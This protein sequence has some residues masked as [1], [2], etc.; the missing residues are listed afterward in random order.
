[1]L[2]RLA[3]VRLRPA[4]ILD[5]GAGTGVLG[6][7]LARRFPRARIVALDV[8]PNMLRVGRSRASW[9]RRWRGKQ[10]FIC[11]AAEKLPLAKQSV[12]MVVSNLT[13]QWCPELDL[14]FTECRRVL[15]PGGLMMFS[16]LG[17]DTLKELRAS[18]EGVDDFVHVHGFVDMHDVGD[19]L[20]RAGFSDTVMEREDLTVTY[21][22]VIDLMKDLKAIGAHNS[23]AARPP[24]LTGKG[25]LTEVSARYEHFRRD[26]KLPATHEVIYG[27][28][29]APDLQT[30]TQ[31]RG[32]D[33]SIRV[34]ITTLRDTRGINS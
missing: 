5:V 33:G 31:R 22:H 34:P 10:V 20:V 32:P 19:A 15:R 7:E 6:N 17:P 14:V 16:T 24:G 12:D 29:W 8:A 25:R 11:G 18:W 28:S 4:S 23:T 27:H 13:L 30:I 1:M 2:E 21:Q 26:G 9:L 3:L